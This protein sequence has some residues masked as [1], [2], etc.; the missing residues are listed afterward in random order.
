MGQKCQVCLHPKRLEIDRELVRGGNVRA[1]SKRYGVPHGSL[2]RHMKNHLSRQLVKHHETQEMLHNKNLIEEITSLLEKA[3]SIME[4]AEEEDQ[5]NTV[6]KGIA[7]CRNTIELLCKLS[8]YLHEERRDQE[9]ESK[10]NEIDK[11]KRLDKIELETLQDLVTKIENEEDVID[12]TPI[13]DK[14]PEFV[15][16]SRHDSSIDEVG[17]SKRVKRDKK[18]R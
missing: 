10:R 14:P 11:L 7:E 13:V 18:K 12:V 6:L 15:P 1:M 9:K 4:K 16:D 2:N 17:R 3:K 5:L 8:V